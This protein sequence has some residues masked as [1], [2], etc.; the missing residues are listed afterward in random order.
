MPQ[1]PI[2][3]L[4]IDDDKS[5]TRLICKML[6]DRFADRLDITETD[7]VQMALGMVTAN[8]F[9]L[10]ITDLD[11]P[12]VNGFKLLKAIKEADTLTQVIILTGY[13]DENAIRSAFI[14]G[15]DDYLLKP[16]SSEELCNSVQFMLN[17]ICRLRSE[18]DARV[19]KSGMD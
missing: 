4:V 2:R 5:I 17:R 9:D 19:V 7:D 13:P 3:T 11:M 6:A 8:Q 14:L 1:S 12:S 18:M 15:A 10:C 16:I